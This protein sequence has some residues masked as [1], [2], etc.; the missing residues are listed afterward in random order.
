MPGTWTSGLKRL[1]LPAVIGAAIALSSYVVASIYKQGYNSIVTRLHDYSREIQETRSVFL[2]SRISKSVINNFED[3][4]STNRLQLLYLRTLAPLK[5]APP[6]D[7]SQFYVVSPANNDVRRRLSLDE[8]GVLDR[9][10]RSAPRQ[11]K[12]FEIDLG[13]Y[14]RNRWLGGIDDLRE[15]VDNEDTTGTKAFLTAFDSLGRERD[16]IISRPAPDKIDIVDYAEW[17][18]ARYAFVE[19]VLLQVKISALLALSEKQSEEVRRALRLREIIDAKCFETYRADHNQFMSLVL[20]DLR[21]QISAT[22]LPRYETRKRWLESAEVALYFLGVLV[23]LAR[24]KPR[25]SEAPAKDRSSAPRSPPPIRRPAP[26]RR[27]NMQP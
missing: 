27:T 22:A 20:D 13:S 2:T 24:E 15:C 12:D 17:M 14:R 10:L 5:D 1:P 26:R 6:I 3:Q 23:A 16:A 11:L 9:L 21:E 25:N 19:R 18:T 8:N 7:D 4:I